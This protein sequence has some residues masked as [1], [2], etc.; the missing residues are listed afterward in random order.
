MNRRDL[1]N[2]E[3]KAAIEKHM[4]VYREQL[5]EIVDLR[6]KLELVVMALKDEE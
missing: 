1:Q 6:S 3:Y 4:V 5:Y 2:R